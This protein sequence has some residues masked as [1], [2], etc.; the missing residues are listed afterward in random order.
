M[1]AELIFSFMALYAASVS[2]ASLS[3]SMLGANTLMI[4][5]GPLYEVSQ[6]K[7]NDREPYV[8]AMKALLQSMLPGISDAEMNAKG[9]DE[10][11]GLVAGLNAS[12]MTLKGRTIAE[13]ASTQ[14][15]NAAE[16]Q[17]IIAKFK[18]QYLKLQAIQKRPY[19]FVR[20]FNGAK[21]YWIPTEDLP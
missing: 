3:F 9:Y 12:T 2:S 20:E 15:V 11:M 14:A 17:T 5:L 4:R 6:R 19:Q 10:V 18:R 1:D 7:G 13:V 8:K 16:Y 21:Y